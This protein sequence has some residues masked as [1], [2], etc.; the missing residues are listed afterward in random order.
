MFE[1]APEIIVYARHPECLH[2]VAHQHAVRK[3]IVN[4]ASPLTPKGEKQRD[5]TA[6]YLRTR[7]PEVERVF[8]STYERTHAIPLAT[9]ADMPLF[10]D[11]ALDERNMGIWHVMPR[12]EVLRAY[13]DAEDELKANGYYHYKPPYG[14]SCE[15]VEARLR[16]FLQTSRAIRGV[17]TVFFSGHGINGLCLRR[18]LCGGSVDDWYRWQREEHL[19]NASVTVFEKSSGG[20]R[21]TLYNHLPWEGLVDETLHTTL[22]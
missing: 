14:E 7:F 17:R 21:I 16:H 11:P 19:K 8:A 22:A 1:H 12:E 2:N 3:R 4:R 6:E 9:W 10:I 15:E 5:S 20:Y 18:V 13:P